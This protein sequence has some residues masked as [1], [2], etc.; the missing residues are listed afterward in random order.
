MKEIFECRVQI[1]RVDD[2]EY[3]H[4]DYYDRVLSSCSLDRLYKEISSFVSPFWP[5]LKNSPL[6]EKYRDS[7]IDSIKCYDIRHITVH[8]H[9]DY[10]ENIVMESDEYKSYLQKIEEHNKDI[11]VIEAK[12]REAKLDYEY[13]VYNWPSGKI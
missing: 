13:Q 1:V 6:R 5:E 3:P 8:E 11:L 2:C 4:Y 10:D 7:Y 9:F 12:E